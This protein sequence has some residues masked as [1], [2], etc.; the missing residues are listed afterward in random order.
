MRN[1]LGASA[2]VVLAH[3]HHERPTHGRTRVRGAEGQKCCLYLL[4][5][6]K[7]TVVAP[8]RRAGL[9]AALLLGEEFQFRKFALAV[10]ATRR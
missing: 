3:K 7:G 4:R 8:R 1:T 5:W 9:F 6:R 2:Q 10:H